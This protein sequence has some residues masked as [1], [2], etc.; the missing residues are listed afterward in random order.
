MIIRSDDIGINVGTKNDAFHTFDSKIEFW[1]QPGAL[2]K[3][4]F[5]NK[6]YKEKYLH[7]E[8]GFT[9]KMA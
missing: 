4:L 6:I 9:F 3:G 7:I 8:N 1:W 2:K 5:F